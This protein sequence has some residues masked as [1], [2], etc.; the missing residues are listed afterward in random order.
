[1]AQGIES[2]P[3]LW[4]IGLSSVRLALAQPRPGWFAGIWG[5]KQ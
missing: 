4:E 5:V 3:P 2:L 1:M